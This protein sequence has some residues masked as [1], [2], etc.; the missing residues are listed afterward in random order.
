MHVVMGNRSR[1]ERSPFTIDHANLP[2]DLTV[3]Q[4]IILSLISRAGLEN[5]VNAIGFQLLFLMTQHR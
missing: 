4:D 3:G 5:D 2:N 1:D